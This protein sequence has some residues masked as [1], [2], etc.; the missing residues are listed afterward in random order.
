MFNKSRTFSILVLTILVSCLMVS[1]VSADQEDKDRI[2]DAKKHT[3]YS[4]L[5]RTRAPGAKQK[6]YN[7]RQSENDEER[8]C[9]RIGWKCLIQ[10]I[11]NLPVQP[12]PFLN[13]LPG[14]LPFPR[15]PHR[16]R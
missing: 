5:A 7:E 11:G 2:G 10:Y 14:E 4:P 16:F 9:H 13:R 12:F 3:V 1:L 15:A 6:K 8:H